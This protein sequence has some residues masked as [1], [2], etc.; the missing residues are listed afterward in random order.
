M[1]D[2]DIHR[3]RVVR[4]AKAL[5]AR[6]ADAGC[7]RDAAGN[8]TL[9]YSHYASLVL[10]SL[11]NPVM[12]SL[13]GIHTASGFKKVQKQL[14]T[15]RASLGSLS[16]S[17]RVF[18]P[19]L[20]V[21]LIEELLADLPPSHPGPGPRRH[22]PDSIPRELADRLVAADGS[23]LAALPHIVR[24]AAGGDWKLHLQFRPLDGRPRALHLAREHADPER[25]VLRAALEPGCVYLAD[26]GYEQYALYNAV[27]AAKSDYVIRGQD[28]PA[29][30]VEER[31]LSDAAVAARVVSDA[32]V[33]LTSSAR[34]AAAL[35]HPVRRVVI[36]GRD[37]GRPRGDRVETGEVVVYTSL[38]GPPAEVIAAV[39]Q[40][41]W[42]IELFFRFLKQVLGLKRLFSDKPEAVAIQVYCA[43]IACLLLAR[44]VGGRVTADAFRMLSFYLQGWADDEEL[45]A[46]LTKLREREA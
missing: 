16:E 4:R 11:F 36:A 30:V 10:L 32:V 23:A 29:A 37:Q 39:Y 24:A 17:A 41:R 33:R 42:S 31:L 18:D 7:E 13:R 34:T 19:A 26:R 14:G 25:D 28:R 15:G 9:L 5:F 45:L 3:L 20:L 1:A 46:F 22:V 27:V 44:V 43:V 35:D 12:Q 8:R 21:P 2:P 38:L 6:L 40:L